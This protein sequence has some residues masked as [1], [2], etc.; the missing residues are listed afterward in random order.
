M[1]KRSAVAFSASALH[2]LFVLPQF[3]YSPD[4]KSDTVDVICVEPIRDL[5]HR[6]FFLYHEFGHAVHNDLGSFADIKMGRKQYTEFLS[7][8]MFIDDI[9]RCSKFYTILSPF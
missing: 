6:S 5:G 1:H 2:K 7:D 4:L 9:V 8:P 3:D